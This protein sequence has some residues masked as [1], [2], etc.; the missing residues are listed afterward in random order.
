MIYIK[1]LKVTHEYIMAY[2]IKT[3]GEISKEDPGN[4]ISVV[5]CL[6]NGLKEAYQ[7]IRC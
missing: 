4:I 3:L 7:G 6:K 2:V 5:N 1:F